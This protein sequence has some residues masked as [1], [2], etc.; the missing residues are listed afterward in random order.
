MMLIERR[1]WID[2]SGSS[3]STYIQR[4]AT[5]VCCSR[6]TKSR[7]SILFK[8]GCEANSSLSYKE[9]QGKGFGLSMTG[10]IS[11]L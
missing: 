2:I 3:L 11:K 9:R 8:A 4:F 7:D 6:M 1:T 5:H 10:K